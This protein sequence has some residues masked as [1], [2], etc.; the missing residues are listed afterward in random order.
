MTVLAPMLGL[1]GG[2]LVLTGMR[3]RRVNVGEPDVPDVALRAR[4]RTLWADP[5]WSVAA[6]LAGASIALLVTTIPV[7]ALLSALVASRIPAIVRHHRSQRARWQRSLAWPA[8]LDDV[9]SAMRAGLDLPEALL[10]AGR[11]APAD[12]RLPFEVFAG[13]YARGGD[14]ADAL[15]DMR[16]AAADPV[17]D[18][19]AQALAIA[20]RVGGGDLTHVLRSL[21]AFLRVDLQVRGEILARQSWSV[22]SAR[23]AVAAPW[24]VLA[25]LATRPST[26]DAYRTIV[27]EILLVGV[28]VAS[29][30]AYA[31]MLRIARIEE[32]A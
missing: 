13:S 32:P 18:Q 17:V 10:H 15:E 8:V 5:A 14:F 31:V 19:T 12:M 16:A 25:M 23:M 26:M 2:L 4:A 28:A 24:I 21:G 1:I 27:G 30:V 6:A 29:A 3:A 7:V 22:N 9:T 20:R 11:H